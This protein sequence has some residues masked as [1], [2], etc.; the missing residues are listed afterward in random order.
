MTTIAD[1][2]S[3]ITLFALASA[4]VTACFVESG[5]DSK[6]S[7]AGGSGGVAQTPEG[8]I[9]TNAVEAW[10]KKPT[11]VPAITPEELVRACAE[12]AACNAPT[13]GSTDPL[14]AVSICVAELEW[15]AERA[16]PA[17]ALF[18][19]NERVEYYVKCQNEHAGDCEAQK[20]CS[21]GR[22]H[23][24]FCEEDGCHTVGSTKYTVTCE[25]S[26][27]HLTAGNDTIDRDCAV[28][29][30]ECDTESSTGCTDRP[31]TACPSEGS[32][33]DRCDDDIRL[34]CDGKG[35]VSYHDC[36]V[37]G[38]VC[39]TAS[40]G[41]QDCVYQDPPD[42]N[43]TDPEVLPACADGQLSVC[44]NGASVTVNGAGVCPSA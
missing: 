15:S 32:K 8:P 11:A 13:S 6:P 3:R 21:S 31:F 37:L 25:G 24:I 16:I 10:P 9:A 39:G 41:S 14:T 7:N 35:Q 19:W 43:C 33:A 42:P 28:A 29:Y 22:S 38:G 5:S 18:S 26:I 36:S 27:A 12:Q 23:A 1:R 4:S 2:C 20:S 40:D 17:S 44:L 34:G 30:A